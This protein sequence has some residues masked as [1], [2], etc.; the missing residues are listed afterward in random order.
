MSK[1]LKIQLLSGKDLPA[2]DAGSF[3]FRSFPREK[4]NNKKKKK[5]EKERL[6]GQQQTFC[7][8]TGGT[9]DPYCY[10]VCGKSQTPKSKYKNK[11]LNPVWN[12]TFELL[13]DDQN[14]PLVLKCYDHD[15]FSAD[16]FL[17]ESVILLRNLV[18]NEDTSMTV[19]VF[20]FS[21]P[22]SSSCL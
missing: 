1:R 15:T 11:T 18:E 6:S 5:G 20:S 3:P 9:S 4:R 12:E 21:L 22:S 2:A 10:F 14:L 13:I 7:H 16:D 8:Q 17:G 19:K